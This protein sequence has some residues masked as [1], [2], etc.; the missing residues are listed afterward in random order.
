[1]VYGC[2]R[3]RIEEEKQALRGVSGATDQGVYS[4]NAE[5]GLLMQICGAYGAVVTQW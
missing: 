5:G 4:F 1:M 3:V 2:L